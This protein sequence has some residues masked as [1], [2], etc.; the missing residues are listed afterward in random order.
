MPKK[1]ETL[2]RTPPP[3][4]SRIIPQLKDEMMTSATN[5]Y[6]KIKEDFEVIPYSFQQR[7]LG[8]LEIMTGNLEKVVDALDEENDKKKSI[9]SKNT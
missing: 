1:F 4:L 6:E 3:K 5:A 7:D 9:T 2:K 8:R